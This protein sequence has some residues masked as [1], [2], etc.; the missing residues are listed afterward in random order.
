MGILATLV[1][2][3]KNNCHRGHRGKTGG[4]NKQPDSFWVR[5]LK[6]IFLVVLCASRCPLWLTAVLRFICCPEKFNFKGP[7]VSGEQPL[8]RSFFA[9]V[10]GLAG[11]D[12][13]AS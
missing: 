6:Q 10:P 3:S 9:V 8:L 5:D 7:F 13:T 4:Y 1:F 2:D 12:T 11:S